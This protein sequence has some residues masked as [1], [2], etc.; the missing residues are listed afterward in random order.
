[1]ADFANSNIVAMLY[2]VAARTDPA[3]VAGL[4]MVDANSAGTVHGGLKRE[5]VGRIIELHG[6]HLLFRVGDDL[7]A[8]ADSPILQVFLRSPDALVLAEKWMRLE[9][10]HHASNRTHIVASPTSWVCTRYASERK[11]GFGENCV[12]AGFFIGLLKLVGAGG[13]VLEAGGR[14]VDVGSADDWSRQNDF[15]GFTLRWADFVPVQDDGARDDRSVVAGSVLERLQSLVAEDVARGWRIADA[16]NRLALSPRSLQRHLSSRNRSFSS[17]VRQARVAEAARLL[18][19]T[20][21]AL[22]EIAFCC[23]YADQAHFQ[24]DFRRVTNITPKI[25]RDMTLQSARVGESHAETRS[26]GEIGNLPAV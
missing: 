5:L 22:A 16:A 6:P 14:V 20:R 11:P 24:R 8:F 19:S 3:L 26:T 2:R 18:C 17:V 13:V 9:R 7:A 21:L 1:M 23:G 12:I 25:H 10:F 15:S 4:P